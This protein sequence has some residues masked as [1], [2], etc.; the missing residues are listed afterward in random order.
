MEMVKPLNLERGARDKDVQWWNERESS[1]FIFVNF[2]NRL[3][4]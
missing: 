3:L 4:N 2:V 1:A